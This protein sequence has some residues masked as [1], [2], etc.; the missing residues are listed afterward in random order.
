MNLILQNG[1]YENTIIIWILISLFSFFVL[2]LFKPS[3]Y[4][5]H[6]NNNQFT[7]DN[8]LGWFLMELPT[9][10]C[11][12]FFFFRHS[13]E[14]NYVT[15]CFFTL[16]MMHYIYRVFIFP[17]RIRTKG[18]KIPLLVVF[19]A[20]LFN[21]C[22]TYF[23]G[24][25][26]NRNSLLYDLSWFSSIY[27]IIGIIIF[28]IGGLINHHSDSILI[29]LRKDS[30]NEYKIP[31]GGFFKYVSC[32]NHFGEIIEWIGFAVLTWSLPGLAFALWTAS[33]LIPRSIQH[34]NWYKDKFIEY[35]KGRKA[36]VPFII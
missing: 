12:P 3:T 26:F 20:I 16:Y 11:M 19:S 15:L 6:I 22:N 35:P 23:L 30:K 1:F 21:I 17:F 32:A 34:H 18:K 8:K 9:V 36:V 27:F 31:F 29:N 5:R 10:L 25:Y 13:P 24:D 4:G 28:I 14:H 7:I 33:N 2:L